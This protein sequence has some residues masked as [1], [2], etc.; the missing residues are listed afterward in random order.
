MIINFEQSD[1]NFQF[2]GS[3][4]NRSDETAFEVIPGLYQLINIGVPK[5]SLQLGVELPL[6]LSGTNV[7]ENSNINSNTNISGN[8]ERRDQQTFTTLT[9]RTGGLSYGISAVLGFRYD[10]GKKWKL[11]AQLTPGFRYENRM[12]DLTRTQTSTSTS[13]IVINGQPSTLGSNSNESVTSEME[14]LKH[15]NLIP[16]QVNFFIFYQL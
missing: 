13:I 5:F 4:S 14:K 16:N 12:L 10:I 6:R 2:E 15:F 11:G 8:E 7:L 3:S 1:F 9:E